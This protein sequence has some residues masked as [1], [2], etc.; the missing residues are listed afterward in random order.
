MGYL[1]IDNLYK[2]TDI[3]AFKKVY[4]LEKVHGT[5]AHI[6]FTR[7]GNIP[8]DFGGP[9]PTEYL[10]FF[11]G[12]EKPE[13]FAGLFNYE[14]L[15]LRFMASGADKVTI[16][17]E[18][19]GGAQQKMSATYGP[20]LRFV[21]FDVQIDD[22]WLSVPQA[23]GF[24]TSMG[25]EFVDYV[26]IDA[27]LELLNAYRDCDSTQAIR[28]GMGAGK[29]REGIVIR[30]PFEVTLN[31]GKR[32]ITK[33]KRDEFKE[34]AT[35]REISPEKLAVLDS[36]KAVAA[37]WVTDMRL[38]HI[39][40]KLSPPASDMTDAKRV[41]IAMQED[42]KREGEGEIVWSLAVESSIGRATAALFKKRISKI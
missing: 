14:D 8:T 24:C 9:K 38:T 12:N 19:Y 42:I 23:H 32:L 40:D 25:I 22:K 31:N 21:A 10:S 6:S 37:E 41:I 4:A 18:A 3:L 16:Y 29:M 26:L 7:N 33:H 28:N 20:T 36:A 30:P 5:S 35:P 34:T 17:G 11:G 27:E 1:H 2:N 39:L 15:R 13:K